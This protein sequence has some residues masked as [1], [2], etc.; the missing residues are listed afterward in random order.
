MRALVLLL[1]L[2]F[3]LGL[4]GCVLLRLQ[5]KCDDRVGCMGIMCCIPGLAQVVRLEFRQRFQC[6]RVGFSAQEG[7]GTN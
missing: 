5:C 4:L 1:S 7:L 6:G 3:F 2:L